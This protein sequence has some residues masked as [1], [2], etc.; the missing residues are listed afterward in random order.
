[1]A[2]AHNHEVMICHL[3][4]LHVKEEIEHLNVEVKHLATWIHD[5]RVALDQAIESCTP[6]QPLLARMIT[7]FADKRKHVNTNLQVR[8]YQI[9][10]LQGFSG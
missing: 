6:T 4:I 5:K 2:N 7:K 9:Y 1:W 8:L 10:C 3:K